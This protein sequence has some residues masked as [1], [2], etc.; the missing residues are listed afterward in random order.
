M[1]VA[2][3][4][5]A[6]VV[7]RHGVTKLDAVLEYFKATADEAPDDPFA[8]Q[9]RIRSSDGTFHTMSIHE[10]TVADIHAATKGVRRSQRGRQ[11]GR[12]PAAWRRRAERLERGLPPA[13]AGT[14][15]GARVRLN[16]A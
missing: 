5:G 10:A 4:F 16:R 3:S 6:A 14:A 1:R 11:Q 8:V 13:P 9:L 15:T 2:R 12:I 7:A